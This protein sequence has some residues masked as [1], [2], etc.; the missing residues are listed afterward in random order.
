M[1]HITIGPDEQWC[2]SLERVVAE[3]GLGGS[4]IYAVTIGVPHL[5]VRG[6][7]FSLVKKRGSSG[8]WLDMA[9]GSAVVIRL[10]QVNCQHKE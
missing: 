4:L 6:R 9:D 10:D 3:P 2:A 5:T 1:E 7:M 8:V